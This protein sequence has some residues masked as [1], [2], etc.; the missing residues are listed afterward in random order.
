MWS[1][2]LAWSIYK[3]Q[4]NEKRKEKKEKSLLVRYLLLCHPQLVML[5]D[6]AREMRRAIRALNP[7]Q[8]ARTLR[9]QLLL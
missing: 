1:I 7:T 9:N 6:K 4:K 5:L 8:T 3:L 2:Q